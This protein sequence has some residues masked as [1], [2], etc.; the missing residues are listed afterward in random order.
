MKSTEAPGRK[1]LFQARDLA[2]GGLLG[3]LGIVLPMAFH[4]LGP[5]AGTI[6]LPMHLPILALGMLAG[7]E[8]ALIVGFATPL[9]SA[10]LTGMPPMAP[11]VA[12]LMSFELAGLGAGAAL[13]RRAR[14]PLLLVGPGA[15]ILARL[16]RAAEILTI[17]PMLGFDQGLFAFVVV[18]IV[19]STPGVLLQLTVVPGV[20]HLVE[21]ASS[22]GRRPES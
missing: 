17:G 13:L 7:W 8:T 11:P 15:I 3:A 14:V 16:V 12:L 18:S 4:V 10:A 22:L 20:V 2:L 5:Q 21:R 19:T 6:F 9:I 1:G